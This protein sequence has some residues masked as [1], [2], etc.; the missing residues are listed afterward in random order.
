MPAWSYSNL[1]KLRSLSAAHGLC[2]QHLFPRETRS[3]FKQAASEAEGHG[4]QRGHHSFP[5][6]MMHC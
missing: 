1:P 6:I 4:V 2:Q 5:N 3:P